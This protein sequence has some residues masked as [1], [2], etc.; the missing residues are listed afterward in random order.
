MKRTAGTLL[1]TGLLIAVA[2]QTTLAQENYPSK[3]ITIVYPAPAGSGVEVASRAISEEV[4]RILGQPLIFE[5]RPGAL[6]RL[7]IKDMPATPADGYFL[8]LVP[9]SVTVTQII[10]DKNFKFKLHE[11]YEP[12][13]VAVESPNVIVASASMP[14][15]D[16]EGLVEYAR[17]NPGKLNVG[18]GGVGG[19]TQILMAQLFKD[20]DIEAEMIPYPGVAPALNDMLAGQID[21]LG[22]TSSAKQYVDNGT[23]KAIATS[24]E[25]RWPLFPDTPTLRES[26]YDI[27]VSTYFT[28]LVKPG[29][30]KPVIDR[31]NETFTQAVQSPRVQAIFAENGYIAIEATPED[32]AHRIT[33]EITKNGPVIEALDLQFN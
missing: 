2:P 23:L 21:L 18:I 27:V 30:P 22:L 6:Y 12:V 13:V 4:S 8:N 14:F 11:D 32:V 29:T 19:S 17:A 20:A 10:A 25:E 15:D 1:I 9:E 31:L 5:N 24:S 28:L 3:P 16:V 26:G 33:E 7:G